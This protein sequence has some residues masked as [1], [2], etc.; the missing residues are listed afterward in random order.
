MITPSTLHMRC[1]RTCTTGRTQHAPQR[2]SE[3]KRL[4]VHCHEGKP[5]AIASV[6]P[7]RRVCSRSYYGPLDCVRDD[8]LCARYWR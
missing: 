1:A 3:G 5:V 7:V 4:L 8:V 2:E 6:P